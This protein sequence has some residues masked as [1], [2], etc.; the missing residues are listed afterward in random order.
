MV[1]NKYLNDFIFSMLFTYVI[2]L[3]I[4]LIYEQVMAMQITYLDFN[5]DGSYSMDEIAKWTAQDHIN[6][7]RYKGEHP[8]HIMALIGY[9]IVAF[10][11]GCIYTL[12]HWIKDHSMEI[13]NKFL[14][15]KVITKK[16][17]M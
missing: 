13:L 10:G 9:P 16:V 5:N 1:A 7:A 15:L 6:Y 14:N 4:F 2:L 8:K 12:S 3:S 11:F 17:S